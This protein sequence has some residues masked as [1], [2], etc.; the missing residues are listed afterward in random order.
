MPAHQPPFQLTHRL[1][2]LVA[3]IAER[4]GRGTQPTVSMLSRERAETRISIDLKS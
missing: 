2:A 4:L 1:T 3:D